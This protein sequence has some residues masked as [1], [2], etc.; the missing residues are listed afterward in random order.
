MKQRFQDCRPCPISFPPNTRFPGS[1][2][3]GG[4]FALV[5]CIMM[6]GC[7]DEHHD[8]QVSTNSAV[9]AVSPYQETPAETVDVA[10]TN[11]PVSASPVGSQVNKDLYVAMGDS[12]TQ[13]DPEADYPDMLSMILGK[14]VINAGKGGETTDDGIARIHDL[15]RSFQPG[16]LLIL[17]GANDAIMSV[18]PDIT[19]QNL[20]TMI[21]ATK[22]NHTI[23]VLATLTP[24]FGSHEL[25]QSRVLVLNKRIRSLAA[26]KNVRLASLD[27]VITEAQMQSDGL[28]PTAE[29]L[30]RIAEVFAST[31]GASP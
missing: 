1:V 19:M 2:L 18:D 21:D 3:L 30:H 13:G 20:S 14:L 28:H 8:D 6:S 24:M 12:I 27:K 5:F 17:Y 7:E 15:L 29:G 11:L 25:Y 10:S 16:W 9:D 31:I 4:V 26:Q 23:P 22:A